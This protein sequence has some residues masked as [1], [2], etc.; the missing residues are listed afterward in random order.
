V[1]DDSEV[2]RR[3][4][5]SQLRHLGYGLRRNSFHCLVR[6]TLTGREDASFLRVL[7]CR[8]QGGTLPGAAGREPRIQ[9]RSPL[10]PSWMYPCQSCLLLSCGMRL[11]SEGGGVA[12]LRLKVNRDLGIV[13][14]SEIK[15][16]EA[17]L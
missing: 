7:R 8:V 9:S 4:A 2:N 6:K 1:V 16:G 3:I 14:C 10:F 17:L 13:Q 11:S 5:T 15:L 12:K